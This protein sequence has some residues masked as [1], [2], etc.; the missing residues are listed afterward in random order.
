M[1]SSSE[2]ANDKAV[3][4]TKSTGG[5]NAA[6]PDDSEA[7]G[8]LRDCEMG[9]STS[10][11]QDTQKR[12]TKWMKQNLMPG[13]GTEGK[14][15]PTTSLVKPLLRYP[16]GLPFLGALHSLE[17]FMVYRKFG[18]LQAQVLLYKQSE[19]IK[20]ERELQQLGVNVP[21]EIPEYHYSLAGN[22]EEGRIRKEKVHEIEETFKEYAQLLS[23]ARDLASYDSPSTCNYLN[24]K[25]FF[26]V[27]DIS[28]DDK[29][30]Y[31]PE[32]LVTLKPGRDHSWLDTWVETTLHKIANHDWKYISVSKRDNFLRLDLALTAKEPTRYIFCSGNVRENAKHARRYGVNLFSRERIEFLVTTIIMVAIVILMAIPIYTLSVIT[33][34]TISIVILGA[35]TVLFSIVLRSFTPAKRHE[36]LASAAAYCAVLVVFVGNL[37]QKDGH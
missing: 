16:D 12:W 18:I 4:E 29:Y 31:C 20:L 2:I 10:N 37:G 15:K 27:S 30:L 9:N 13:T 8:V 3:I 11:C 28:M 32:D 23:V 19:L 34:R 1:P 36:I 7:K 33:D 21:G 14:L 22:T 35:F 26:D 24:M 25:S 6:Q 5:P 17:N